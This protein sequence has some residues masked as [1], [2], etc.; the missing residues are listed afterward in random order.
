[1][2]TYFALYMYRNAGNVNLDLME[3][4][5][6]SQPYLILQELM[7][8]DFWL[9]KRQSLGRTL[10]LVHFLSFDNLKHMAANNRKLISSL[11]KLRK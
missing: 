10:R 7:N 4:D 2:E 1:M 6:T 5:S 3:G 9:D 8:S 11:H